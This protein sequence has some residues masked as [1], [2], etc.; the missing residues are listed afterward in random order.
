MSGRKNKD[1]DS[2]SDSTCDVSCLRGLLIAFNFFFILAGCGALAVGIWTILGKMDF[3]PL[4][5]SA[6]YTLIVYM[7]IVVGVV[8]LITGTIG[9]VGATQKSSRFLTI[10]FIL[11]VVLLIIEIIAGITS[12]VYRQSIHD[13]LSKDL[14]NNINS[15]YN[16][17]DSKALTQAVD[18]MQQRFECCGVTAHTNWNVSIACFTKIFDF[19]AFKC[20][21]RKVYKCSK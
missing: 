11:M 21:R 2:R 14:M 5:S 19:L 8:I 3:S 12:F 16:Q 6:T 15:N 20:G 17:T 1:Y 10:Y 18:T 9:C 13:E 4:L 7:L